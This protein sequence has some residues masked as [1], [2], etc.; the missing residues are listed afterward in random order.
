LLISLLTDPEYLLCDTCPPY[1]PKD[2]VEGEKASQESQMPLSPVVE[3]AVIL[4]VSLFP[5]RLVGETESWTILDETSK[6]LM[7]T[8][9]TGESLAAKG[10]AMEV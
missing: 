10:A 2:A 3:P 8:L 9:M 4:M 1:D 6:P 5:W 7:K